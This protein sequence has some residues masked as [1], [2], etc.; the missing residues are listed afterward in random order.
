MPPN[1]SAPSRDSMIQQ[2]QPST[3]GQAFYRRQI[4]LLEVADSEGLM[5]QYHENACLVTFE[6]V[7]EGRAAIGAYLQRYLEHLGGLKLRSTDRFAETRD[8]IFFEASVATGLGAARVQ[9]VF[10]LREGRAT[11]H[12]AGVLA[13]TPAEALA[14]QVCAPC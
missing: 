7:V 6:A 2:G 9:D 1:G 5:S 3:P 13:S 4:A 10:M 14:R 12:F 8:A 11:H